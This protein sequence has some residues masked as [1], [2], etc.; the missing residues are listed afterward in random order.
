MKKKLYLSK[1]FILFIYFCEKYK[2][3]GLERLQL[4]ELIVG[5]MGLYI[6]LWKGKK[7]GEIN[8]M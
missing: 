1:C 8:I 5:L 4:I 3:D 7:W 6:F 2:N